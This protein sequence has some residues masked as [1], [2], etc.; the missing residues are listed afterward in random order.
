V[1]S[2]KL[3]TDS[4]VATKIAAGAVTTV[5]LADGAAGGRKLPQAT[6]GMLLVGGNS[7]DGQAS[8]PYFYPRVLS[9]GWNIDRTG[10]MT[11]AAGAGTAFAQIDEEAPNGTLGGGTFAFAS[12][13]VPNWYQRGLYVPWK[14]SFDTANPTNSA[15]GGMVALY[16]LNGKKCIAFRQTGT[17]LIMIKTPGYRC[18]EFKSRVSFF[19]NGDITTTPTFYYGTGGYS[20]STSLN[21]MSYSEVTFIAEISDVTTLGHGPVFYVDQWVTALPSS[22]APTT[23][24][25][26]FGYASSSGPGTSELYG[27]INILKLR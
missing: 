1:S 7:E 23:A 13:A 17:Y 21:A 27:R 22:A 18:G 3:A 4:V 24:A 2:T 12:P 14:I 16:D 6:E 11:L 20:V 25:Q 5:K 9:G 15:G 10:L 26:V 19:S 8:G